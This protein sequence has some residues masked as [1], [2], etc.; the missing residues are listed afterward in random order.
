MLACASTRA[1]CNQAWYGLVVAGGGQ[2]ARGLGKAKTLGIVST[3]GQPK[4]FTDL[5]TGAYNAVGVDGDKFESFRCVRPAYTPVLTRKLGGNDEKTCNNFQASINIIAKY[6]AMT[7]AVHPNPEPTKEIPECTADGNCEFESANGPGTK[8]GGTIA[9]G[10]T[11]ADG[12]GRWA[13]SCDYY[14]KGFTKDVSSLAEKGGPTFLTEITAYLSKVPCFCRWQV[15]AVNLLQALALPTGQFASFVL[16]LPKLYDCPKDPATGA[17]NCFPTARPYV[18]HPFSMPS[19][20]SSLPLALPLAVLPL[21]YRSLRIMMMMM[22]LVDAFAGV[23]LP[24]VGWQVGVHLFR[25]R[26]QQPWKPLVVDQHSEG[27]QHSGRQVANHQGH[28]KKG[29]LFQG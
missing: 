9:Q 5:L 2:V 1:I 4:T 25:A 21:A 6:T 19:M 3:L 23:G 17:Y 18:Q 22:M 11:W 7:Q 28:P 20:V 13:Q 29:R 24:T 12:G 16:Q 14:T 26:H 8:G 15:A 27:P 10:T